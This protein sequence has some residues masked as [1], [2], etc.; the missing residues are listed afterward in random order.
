MTQGVARVAVELG[1]SIAVVDD[2][3]LGRVLGELADLTRR[4]GREHW[5]LAR[6]V[7]VERAV[8]TSA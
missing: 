4:A 1:A 6:L 7:S 2:P 8:A 3:E 5:E